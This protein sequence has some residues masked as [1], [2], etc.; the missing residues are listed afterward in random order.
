MAISTQLAQ[1]NVATNEDPLFW[2]GGLT[3]PTP[4]DPQSVGHRRLKNHLSEV[5]RET[6]HKGR[7]V[8]IS[9]HGKIDGY[10]VPP[11]AIEELQWAERMRDTLPLLM[12]AVQA[13]AAIPS[14]TLDE[15]GVDIPFD[16]R[17]LHKFLVEYPV[18]I[19]HDEEG[20]PIRWIDGKIE[21]ELI[22]EDDTEIGL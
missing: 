6:V 19:T 18:E 1:R 3:M 15:L 4:I 7:A 9:N 14:T 17:K 2:Y 8:P 11:A 13:G 22:E 21:T 12:A 10:L 20:N 5:L 16:W